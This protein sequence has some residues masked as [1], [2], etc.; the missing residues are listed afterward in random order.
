MASWVCVGWGLDG[1]EWA[2]RNV[3]TLGYGGLGALS[4]GGLLM[5]G[6]RGGWVPWAIGGIAGV[7]SW[8]DGACDGLES[9]QNAWGNDMYTYE[10]QSING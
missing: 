4:S 9:S 3:V 1:S 2:W 8:W 5:D 6:F 10:T 7:D